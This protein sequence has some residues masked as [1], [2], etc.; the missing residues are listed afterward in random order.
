MSVRESGTNLAQSTKILLNQ[1][2]ETK[3]HWRDEKSQQFEADHL[4]DL[5]GKVQRA[6]ALIEELDI[7]L[8]KIRHACE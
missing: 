2:E 6:T 3:T 5:P 8:K 4:S 7:I 1:W